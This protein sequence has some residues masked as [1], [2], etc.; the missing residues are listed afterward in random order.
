M[1]PVSLGV[2]RSAVVV[3][4]LLMGHSA[5]VY[6]LKGVTAARESF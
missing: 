2:T 1:K 3:E 4:D 6:I 5:L